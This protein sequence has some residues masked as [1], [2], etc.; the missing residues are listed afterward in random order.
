[1]FFIPRLIS[2]ISASSHYV[3]IT[4]EIL[5]GSALELKVTLGTLNGLNNIGISIYAFSSTYFL[6]LSLI[7]INS[8]CVCVCCLSRWGS[9]HELGEASLNGHRP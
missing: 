3:M 6:F 1:M 9:G 4:G 7:F 8:V 2:D 5:T